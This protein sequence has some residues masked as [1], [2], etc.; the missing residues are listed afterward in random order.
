MRYPTFLSF[1]NLSWSP[2]SAAGQTICRYAIA[3]QSALRLAQQLAAGTVAGVAMTGAIAGMPTAVAAESLALS[4]DL[5]DR[6]AML[7]SDGPTATAALPLQQSYATSAP[8]A[9]ATTGQSLSQAAAASPASPATPATPVATT[10][11]QPTGADAPLEPTQ[12]PIPAQWWEQGSASPIAVTIGNAE[13]TRRPDGSKTEA[14]YWHEDP[15]NAANNFGTFSYQHLSEAMTAEVEAEPTVAGKRRVAAAQQLAEISDQQ[16]LQRLRTFYGQLQGQA[17]QRGLTLSPLEV[18]NGLDLIN[19]SEAAGLAVGGYVDRLAQMKTVEADAEEQIREARTWSYWHPERQAWDA[20]GLGN[21]YPAVRRDQ[22][23]RFEAVKYSLARYVPQGTALIAQ[24]G[25]VI[26]PEEDSA[27]AVASSP[28]AQPD[29][30]EP[31]ARAAEA[32][33]AEANQRPLNALAQTIALGTEA[34]SLDLGSADMS[35]AEAI[36]DQIIF[37]QF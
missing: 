19:Q 10:T 33:Q 22:D 5:G 36:A 6:E 12:D 13:G 32:A 16:Q 2:L 7:L 1:A 26:A 28:T 9:S 25:G 20:P 8:L 17:R 18:L 4:F 27:I 30:L 14:Y 35:L 3:L 11:G 15:G 23:R 37:S 24:S 34:L 29:A 31:E 21:N